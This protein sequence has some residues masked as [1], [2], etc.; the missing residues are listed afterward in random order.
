[1]NKVMKENLVGLGDGWWKRAR[2]SRR[3]GIKCCLGKIPW[4]E[5]RPV[6]EVLSVWRLLSFC[7]YMLSLKWR[8][9][10]Y[11]NRQLELH[12]THENFQESWQGF[13]YLIIY[14]SWEKWSLQ[15]SYL[16]CCY[17]YCLLCVVRSWRKRFWDQEFKHV[18]LKR[19]FKKN[20]Y[21]NKK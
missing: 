21:I 6:G 7:L 9:A 18:N 5:I 15:N 17:G 13:Y 2:K 3:S 14:N 8:K 4:T 12:R 16:G 1:M 19:S 10:S 11:R 20:K